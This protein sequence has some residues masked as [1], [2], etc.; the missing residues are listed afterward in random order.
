[1]LDESSSRNVQMEMC[2]TD[3]FFLF[4]VPLTGTLAVFYPGLYSGSVSSLS[5]S[6][7]TEPIGI[8]E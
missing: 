1:M 3:E 8:D 2:I 5:L 6:V 4:I 7:H